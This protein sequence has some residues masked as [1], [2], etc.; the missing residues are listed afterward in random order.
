MRNFNHLY[1]FYIVAKLGGVT[2]AAKQLNTS[3]SSLS[4][5][6]KTLEAQIGLTLFTREGRGL[7]LTR[8]GQ[9]VFKICR[10]MFETATELDHFLSRREHLGHT[11]FSIGVSPD[12]ERPF[13]TDIVSRAISQFI[14]GNDQLRP[15]ITQVSF[16]FEKLVARLEMGDLDAIITSQP[17]HQP[18]IKTLTEVRLAVKAV[19]S[20]R[21]HRNFKTVLADDRVGLVIASQDLR[22][23]WEIDEFLVRKKVR[24][25]IAFES[26]VMGA[27]LRAAV[28]GMGLAFLPEAYIARE[29]ERGAVIVSREPLWSHR[30]FLSA[31]SLSAEEPQYQFLTALT[32]RL[33]EAAN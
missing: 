17:P 28:D 11:S 4:T 31:R 25:H 27:L 2:L 8:D 26:N 18:S 1:Y 19:M 32:R 7:I 20:P 3:Q 29:K 10:K 6:L 5:Q 33:E 16:P 15:V 13:V 23:R 21:L 9:A 24:K 14:K 22:L 30:L 12:V